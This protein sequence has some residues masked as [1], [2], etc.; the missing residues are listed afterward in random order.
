[1]IGKKMLPVSSPF[2][3]DDFHSHKKL[4]YD[5][6][7]VLFLKSRNFHMITEKQQTRF[8]FRERERLLPVDKAKER[9][10]VHEEYEDSF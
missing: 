6:L 8:F 4:I 3:T 2:F 10:E 5:V 7:S 9:S 1:M